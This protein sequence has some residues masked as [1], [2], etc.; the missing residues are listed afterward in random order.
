MSRSVKATGFLYEELCMWHDPDGR[1]MFD[2]LGTFFEPSKHY[3]NPETKRRLKNL[4]EVSGVLSNLQTISSVKATKEDLLRF[5]SKDYIENLEVTSA[6]GSGQAGEATTYSQG[7][8]DIACLSAGMAIN[9]VESVL[10]ANVTNAY[11]LSRPPGHHALKDQ[12]SGF[13]LLANIPIAIEAAKSKG[14]LNKVVVVDWD[15]HHGN[16]TQDAF[17][18]RDDVFTI[19]IHHENNFPLNSGALEERG[20]GHGLGYNLNIPL[21]AGCGIGAYE[22]VINEIV[23]PTINAYQP[24]LI[25]VACGFDACALDPLGPMILNSDCYRRMTQS[26]MD[27]AENVCDGMLVAVHEGGYSETYAPFCGLAVIETLSQQ[28][29]SVND[30]IGKEIAKWGQQDV[31]PHQ[32]QLIEQIKSQILIR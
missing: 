6:K 15:V 21:P 2:G 25:I 9:A 22:T 4:L 18:E 23:V 20:S 29:S 7:G 32:R 12:G 26:L 3:E 19:S 5:H 13:C 30:A 11:S 10:N 8:Y 31:Q 28:T 27:C 17:Y 1:G 14:L 24:D 16:G